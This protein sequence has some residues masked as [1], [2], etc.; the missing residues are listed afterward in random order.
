MSRPR[1]HDGRHRRDERNTVA[2]LL[3]VGV[4][5]LVVALVTLFSSGSFD[6]AEEVSADVEAVGTEPDTAVPEPTTPTG[7][8]APTT[9]T[10]TAPPPQPKYPVS[11]RPNLKREV[12]K[13]MTI[14]RYTAE[15]IAAIEEAAQ[16]RIAER[17][18][19]TLRVGTFNV[20]GSQHTAPGGERRAYPP[21]SVRTPAAAGYIRN[22]GVQV[23]GLQELKPDQLDGLQRLTGMAAYPGYAFGSRDTDNN[24][25]YDPDVFEFVSGSSFRITFMNAVRPQTILRLRHRAT[26]RE[27]Y[28]VNMHASAGDGKYAASRK[29]GHLT[30][31]GV[32]NDL[33]QEG[34]PV[35]LTGDMNGREEFFCRVPPMT[36]LV[37]SIG[38]DVS[39][40]CHPAPRLAVDWVLGTGVTW[41]DYDED[42]STLGRVSD[43][44]FVSATATIPGAGG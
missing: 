3:V 27:M 22:Y 40:G 34:L 5:V 32:I 26:G 25:L 17:L 44:H 2:T 21:A 31:A 4:L 38:G 33:K 24:I 16:R 11:R 39:G 42:R 1:P 7:P 35:F 6:R 28:F 12:V 41:S 37:A 8:T 10:T 43:H 18:P 9:P 15:E 13:G 36:G 19:I 20:L 23:L 29:A 30:A 14:R